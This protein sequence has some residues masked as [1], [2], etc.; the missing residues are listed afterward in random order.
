VKWQDLEVSAP[1]I[2]QL[3]RQSLDRARVALLGK[4]RKNGFPRI[5]PVEP[6]F[7]EGHLL[8][9]AMA[10]SSKVR[11]DLVTRLSSRTH[12]GNGHS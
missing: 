12:K 8:F 4:L 6:Y 10:W 7:A 2:A 1:E 3:G 11:P 5:S 9:G